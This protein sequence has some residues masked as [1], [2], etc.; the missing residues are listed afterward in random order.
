MVDGVAFLSNPWRIPPPHT[1]VKENTAATKT[2]EVAGPPR[3]SVM[4]TN[5]V[6]VNSKGKKA[7]HI[8]AIQAGKDTKMGTCGSRTCAADPMQPPANKNGNN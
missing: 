6:M 4:D 3:A 1:T 7:Q 5:V 8:A 2:G